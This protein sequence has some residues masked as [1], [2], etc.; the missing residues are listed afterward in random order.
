MTY[1]AVTAR[2][3]WAD[4]FVLFVLLMHVDRKRE[5]YSSMQASLFIVVE[6]GLGLML[7]VGFFFF[8]FRK[9]CRLDF[10]VPVPFVFIYDSCR[11]IFPFVCLG[12]GPR[13]G[14]GGGGRE[15]GRGV[16]CAGACGAFSGL[17]NVK[18]SSRGGVW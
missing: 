4:A 18:Y 14:G 6:P 11:V 15:R 8:C 9:F 3:A 5:I 10:T 2:S 17:M 7:H 13:E 16:G 12:G 1:A